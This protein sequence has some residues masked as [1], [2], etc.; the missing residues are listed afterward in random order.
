V[1]RND[2]VL[3][4]VQ[5]VKG[6]EVCRAMSCAVRGSP[7]DVRASAGAADK[8]STAGRPWNNGDGE[9]GRGSGWVVGGGERFGWLCYGPQ[10]AERGVE[11]V[12]VGLS[13][14]C[15]ADWPEVR[16]AA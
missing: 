6:R 4:E 7:C 2:A 14:C 15:D 11:F 16:D 3:R 9:S 13:H 5:R 12:V 10:G 1:L 8:P